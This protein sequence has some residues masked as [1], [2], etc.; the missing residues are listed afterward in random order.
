M[1]ARVCVSVSLDPYNHHDRRRHPLRFI[2]DVRPPVYRRASGEAISSIYRQRLHG[3]FAEPLLLTPA[4]SLTLSQA[5]SSPVYQAF[6]APGISRM[7]LDSR[8]RI[9]GKHYAATWISLLWISDRARFVV[10]GCTPHSA[11]LRYACLS[12]RI[13]HRAPHCIAPSPCRVAQRRAT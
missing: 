13:A 1:R 2:C 7:R 10:G 9:S 11:R 4:L 6:G 5:L 8:A 12:R 3:S